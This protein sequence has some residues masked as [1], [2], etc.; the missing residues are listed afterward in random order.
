MPLVSICELQLGVI[1][2]NK[3]ISAF[4]LVEQTVVRKTDINNSEECHAR[5]LNRGTGGKG[6]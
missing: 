3:T 5:E 1:R 6:N 2:A 4:D